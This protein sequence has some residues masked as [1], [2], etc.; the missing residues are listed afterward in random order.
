[1][2]MDDDRPALSST[3]KAFSLVELSIVLVILG[4]LVGG[5][6]SGQSLI[7]AAELRAATNEY[8]RYVTAVQSFRDKY[9]ALPGDMNNA[10]RFWGNLGGTNCVNSAGT[11]AVA[12][13]TCDG[14]GNGIIVNSAA[15]ASQTA[16]GYQ[17]WRQLAFAGFIEGTYTG[18]VGAGGIEDALLGINVPRS[19]LNNAGWS[20]WNSTI[21]AFGDTQ[22][23]FAD[24]GNMLELGTKVAGSRTFGSLFKPE[25]LWN[26]DTKTDDGRPGTGRLIARENANFSGA[27][28]SKCTTSTANNDYAGAYNLSNSGV[29]CAAY[30]ANAF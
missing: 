6:L 29:I 3:K 19:K 27:A 13:G 20:V 1:M 15:A 5:V 18:I 4:L 8:S 23:Y 9:F 11:A 17:F 28:A 7:R 10:T 24:Y 21:G 30:F 12:T 22:T 16:E 14:N 26:I 2:N 25:E